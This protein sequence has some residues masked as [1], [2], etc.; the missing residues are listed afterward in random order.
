MEIED[1]QQNHKP[2][3]PVP[4]RW[5]VVHLRK[6]DYTYRDIAERL[7]I[8]SSGCEAIYSKYLKTGCRRSSQKRKAKEDWSGRRKD[9]D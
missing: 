4:I 7:S 2:P 9:V 1:T 8:S 6:L 5:E 3:I